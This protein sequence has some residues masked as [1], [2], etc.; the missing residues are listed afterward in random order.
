[1]R[2]PINIKVYYV[3]M[4]LTLL[5]INIH[6]TEV[7]IFNY[8]SISKLG[9]KNT[10]K[11]NSLIKQ[12]KS[13]Y[14]VNNLQ[15]T[16]ELYIEGLKLA[17]NP[18]WYYNL[19]ELLF[20]LNEFDN[21]Q[22]SFTMACKTGYLKKKLAYYNA[23][24]AASMARN[25]YM[26]S[27]N[28]ELA[29]MNNYNSWE[30]MK[31]DPDLESF[32]SLNSFNTL[33]NRYK[34][35]NNVQNVSEDFKSIRASKINSVDLTLDGDSQIYKILLFTFD[36]STLHEMYGTYYLALY[37]KVNNSWIFINKTVSNSR[38]NPYLSG[39][40]FN[41]HYSNFKSNKN[42][43][44]TKPFIS[45]NL[46]DDKGNEIIILSMGQTYNSGKIIAFYKGELIEV[47]EIEGFEDILKNK[48]DTIL[49]GHK[50]TDYAFGNEKSSFYIQYKY[51]N[52]VL[53]P[54]KLDI[55]TTEYIYNKK[56]K[57]FNENVNSSTA[58]SLF[59]FL[60][61]HKKDELSENWIKINIIDRP[62]FENKSNVINMMR[63][64]IAL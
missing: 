35:P 42:M 15:K 43:T 58:S 55:Y 59:L 51:L 38:S 7:D 2:S 6:C 41:S 37:K 57:S 8:N 48:N 36:T 24:C 29:L 22:K 56:L 49:I 14:K 4:F 26:A 32:R 19:G 17:T 3:L 9:I 12:A 62:D 34:L 23:A 20:D 54:G 1:M 40:Y 30:H 21:S 27:L 64:K 25:I 46:D 16:K 31:V 45:V 50:V 44:I 53:F 61:N 18:M 60:Y 39:N 11:A 52:G 28:L 33:I 47:G 5:N 13:Y 10:E 63:K